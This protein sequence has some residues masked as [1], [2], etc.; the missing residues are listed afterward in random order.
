V[1]VQ[2]VKTLEPPERR[3]KRKN[4]ERFI[5]NGDGL[6][7]IIGSERPAVEQKDALARSRFSE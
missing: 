4:E 5:K 2:L 3:R 6:W 7:P 1:V